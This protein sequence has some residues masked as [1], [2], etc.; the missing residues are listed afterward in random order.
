VVEGEIMT[1][2]KPRLKFTV[3]EYMTTLEDKR[4]Q[5][6]EGEMILA[7]SPTTTHQRIL[8]NLFRLLDAAFVAT[9]RGRVG[10]FPWDVVLSDYDVVQPDILFISN[11]RADIITEANIQGAPD[12]VVEILSPS[13]GAYD[14][15][16][17]QVLYGRHGVREYWIVDPD[18]ET[19]DVLVEGEDGLIPLGSYGNTGELNTPLLE[20]LTLD[21][22]E[23]FHRN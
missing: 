5:L 3:R 20:G 10:L 15:G 18:A 22:D 1:Q 14:R 2:S 23:L 9:S 17:K 11:E 12:L 21:L 6:L 8:G 16:Y 19:V 13:T 7:P 4:Y